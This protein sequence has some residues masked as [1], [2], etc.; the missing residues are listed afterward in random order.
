MISTVV[1]LLGVSQWLLRRPLFLIGG[2]IIVAISIVAILAPLIA[3][4]DPLKIDVTKRLQAPSSQ[5]IMG[6]DHLGRDLFSRVI[7][8]ARISLMVGVTI[9]FISSALGGALG[10][11]AGYFGKWLDNVIMRICDMFFAFPPLILAMAIAASLGPSLQNT[12]LSLVIVW[13]PRYARLVRSQVLVLRE[14]DYV[15]AAKASGAGHMRIMLKHIVPNALSPVIVQVT[16]DIGQAILMAAS[17]GFL[18]FG[19]QPPTPEW[20][21]IASEAR[22][23]MRDQWWYPTFP[24]VM[25]LLTV[26]GF[27]LVGDGL[28]DVLDPRQRGRLFK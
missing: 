13:W 18:G 25:I 22:I 27:N 17:L 9:A 28:R 7:F 19:A 5:H 4:Q 12:M 1:Q 11:L 2:L 21:V 8:G 6:T 10:L 20:G 14:L 16:L 23:Y 3:P 15:Q 24:S 26:L